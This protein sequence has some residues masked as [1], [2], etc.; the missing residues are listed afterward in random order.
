MSRPTREPQ[1]RR[2]AQQRLT[3]TA[4]TLR[5]YASVTKVPRCCPAFGH[6]Q[7][8]SDGKTDSHCDKVG[9]LFRKM[10]LDCRKVTSDC[11]ETTPD[12][13]R[14]T[15]DCRKRASDCR[16][17][18]PACFVHWDISPV[19]YARPRWRSADL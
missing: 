13:C 12:C 4:T 3:W 15:H 11:R 17:T 5:R 8:Q 1:K 10:T 9:P 19:T 6:R 7:S 18:S 14:M 2:A 16:E